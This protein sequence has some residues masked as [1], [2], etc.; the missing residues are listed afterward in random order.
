M[1]CF[2]SSVSF[3]RMMQV[4]FILLFTSLKFKPSHRHCLDREC[5]S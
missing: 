5:K 2:G 3:K 1:S 4:S